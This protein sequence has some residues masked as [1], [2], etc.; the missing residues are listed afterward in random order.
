LR[1]QAPRYRVI[2]NLVEIAQI[3][4][5][6]RRIIEN[7]NGDLNA[8]AIVSNLGMIAEDLTDLGQTIAANHVA[9]AGK[10]LFSYPMYRNNHIVDRETLIQIMGNISS[11]IIFITDHRFYHR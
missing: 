6:T 2:T 1:V 9:T 5:S 3:L 4:A 10:I 11:A 7:S 8:M